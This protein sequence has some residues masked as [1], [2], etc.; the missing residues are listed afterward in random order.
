[1]NFMAT[2]L[3]TSKYKFV[4]FLLLLFH[5]KSHA[6]NIAYESQHILQDSSGIVISAQQFDSLV[7]SLLVKFKS[8][9]SEKKIEDY[10]SLVKVCNTI[11]FDQLAVSCRECNDLDSLYA[12]KY[13]KII[14]K[15]MDAT[16]SIHYSLYSKKY[17]LQIGGIRTKNNH[18][19][20]I[21]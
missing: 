4:L 19:R 14:A 9:T 2:K 13:L 16:V 20:I 21:H 3:I 6:A 17:D 5:F 10:I 11:G 1:M 12:S 18:F 7:K 15:V 8:D